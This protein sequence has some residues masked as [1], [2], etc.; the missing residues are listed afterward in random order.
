MRMP[1]RVLLAGFVI[2]IATVSFAAHHPWDQLIEQGHYKQA[3][4]LLEKALAANPNDGDAMMQL[5]F[6]KLQF[7]EVQAATKLAERSVTLKPNDA[8]AHAILA[9]CYGQAAE[10]AGMFEGLRLSHSFK[11]ENDAA[12]AIDPRNYE[13]LHSYMQYYLEAPGIA[14]GSKSRAR[15]MAERIA[16]IDPSK[17]A[18][19]HIEIAWQEK[20]FDHL[21]ELYQ[22]AVEAGP[23]SY[24]DVVAMASLYAAQ[25]WRDLPKAEDFARRSIKIDPGRG[26]GYGILAQTK[27]L[28]EQWNQ[29]DQVL[30]EAEQAVP[31]NLVYYFRAGRALVSSGKDNARAER[32]F[33]KYLTQPA[34]GDTPSLAEGH[35]QLGLVLEKL[36]R[37]QEALQEVEAAVKMEPQLKGAK[38]DLKRMKS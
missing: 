29:L 20:Q 7:N 13:A 37:K 35:W 15:E 25:K 5:A 26:L 38:E 16:A 9:D 18:R 31:D 22:K 1:T 14:G 12:L 8:Q 19:A 4:A 2:A 21:V 33:R 3:R 28:S 11:K 6:V 30:A 36:G 34:E 27:A 32:Y 17:G 23:D 24:D 10:N